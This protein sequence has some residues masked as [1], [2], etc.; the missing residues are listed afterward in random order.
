MVENLIGGVYSSG[1]YGD[2][3]LYAV[4]IYEW[5]SVFLPPSAFFSFS[6]V[7][8]HFSLFLRLIC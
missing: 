2:H 1:K 5:L 7:S 6:L 4:G 3:I 8:L